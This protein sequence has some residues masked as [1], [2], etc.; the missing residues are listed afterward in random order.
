MGS[1]EM[2]F[3]E[4]PLGLTYQC[5]GCKR[6]FTSPS[7]LLFHEEGC[8]YWNAQRQ[9]NLAAIKLAHFKEARDARVSRSKNKGK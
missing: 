1:A 2:R 4:N 5:G 9:S 3:N 8:L 6:K 7:V